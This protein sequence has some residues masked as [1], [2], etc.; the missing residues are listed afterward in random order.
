[1]QIPITQCAVLQDFGLFLVQTE[2]RL[3][4]YLLDALVGSNVGEAKGQQGPQQVSGQKD[5][6]FF[7]VGVVDNRT[8]VVYAK[9]DGV[10]TTVLKIMEPVA[11]TERTRVQHTRFLGMGGKKTE[12]FRLYKE[13]AVPTEVYTLSF[14][15]SKFALVCAPGFEILDLVT[16][17]TGSVSREIRA[18]CDTPVALDTDIKMWL[19]QF[20][21]WVTLRADAGKHDPRLALLHKRCTESR[22]IALFRISDSEFLFCYD[23]ESVG[24]S[25]WMRF[26]EYRLFSR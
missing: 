26:R 10:S 22:A 1:M 2:G 15:R 18:C 12:W 11:Q 25:V 6:T 14:T 23:S 17:K 4:A 13:G 7:R 24:Y 3:L 16:L 5:I 8:L 19:Q 20:P 9:R 21:N